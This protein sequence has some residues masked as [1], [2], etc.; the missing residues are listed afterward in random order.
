MKLKITFFAVLFAIVG[1]QAQSPV[2]IWKTVDD[3]TGEAKSHVEIYEEGGKIHGK[4]VK[5][6][7]KDPSTK[8]ISHYWDW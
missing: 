5:L 7:Q 3:N 1:L 8:K 2:G 6:L 4:L